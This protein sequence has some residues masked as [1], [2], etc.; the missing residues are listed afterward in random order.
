[1]NRRGFASIIILLSAVGILI[2]GGIWYY[3]THKPTPSQVAATQN[4]MAT[5][6][7]STSTVSATAASS[8]IACA[9]DFTDFGV[10][11]LPTNAPISTSTGYAWIPIT[12]GN[13]REF[14]SLSSQS[15]STATEVMYPNAFSAWPASLNLTLPGNEWV[16]L[17]G[18]IAYLNDSYYAPI[19]EQEGWTHA[20]WVPIPGGGFQLNSETDGYIKVENGYFRS[21]VLSNVDGSPSYG[22]IVLAYESDIVPLSQ[23]VPGSQPVCPSPAVKSLVNSTAPTST[24]WLA[25]IRQTS[26][27]VVVVPS[28][29][30]AESIQGK[31]AFLKN[32]DV[33]VANQ[34]G[35]NPSQLTHTNGNVSTQVDDGNLIFSFS[36]DYH[37]LA[38]FVLSPGNSFASWGIDVLDL[39][40]NQV[41][42][43]IDGNTLS[44]F[45]AFSQISQ[46]Q[47]PRVTFDAW[48]TNSEFIYDAWG[49]DPPGGGTD[50]YGHLLVNLQTGTTTVI[51]PQ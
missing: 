44:Q 16:A 7:I 42:Q 2:I 49:N 43:R 31:V 12:P 5:S 28:S 25:S 45:S 39:S 29:S 4:T 1:M 18:N 38:Y 36:P 21:I 50:E 41:V 35:S 10:P 37:Y 24:A 32:G 33:W 26:P 6:T 9:T 30:S 15:F 13:T 22:T 14:Y 20:S 23:V 8:S 47:T 46:Y 40:T 17:T 27:E 19:L 51:Q 34:D 48:T 11:P 3:E